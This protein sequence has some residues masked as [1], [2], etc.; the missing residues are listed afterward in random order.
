MMP[1][2]K[3]LSDELSVLV[4]APVIARPRPAN[5]SASRLGSTKKRPAWRDVGVQQNYAGP[6]RI[7]SKGEKFDVFTRPD[8]PGMEFHEYVENGKRRVVGVKKRTGPRKGLGS[9]P[10]GG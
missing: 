4:P 10:I 9:S 1:R 3:T 8:K 7:N 2:K 6:A 5:Q